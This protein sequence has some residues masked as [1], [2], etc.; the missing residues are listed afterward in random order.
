MQVKRNL[1]I[2][3]FATLAVVLIS[4]LFVGGPQDFNGRIIV[5]TWNAGHA[6]LFAI[7][8]FALLSYTRLKHDSHTKQFIFAVAFSL[9]FGFITEVIQ[10]LIGRNLEVKDLVNDLI[11]GLAGLAFALAV[12]S[13]N[14]KYTIG[15]VFVGAFLGLI[16]IRGLIVSAID[17]YRISQEFPLLSGFESLIE[18]NRWNTDHA[19]ISLSDKHTSSGS[20]SMRVELLPAKYP[21]IRLDH[22]ERNWQNK[23]SINFDIF[24]ESKSPVT[25]VLKIYD[26]QHLKTGYFFSDRY[27]QRFTLLPGQNQF[28]FALADIQSAPANREMN[29][30]NIVAVSLFTVHL[31]QPLVF[32]IDTVRLSDNPETE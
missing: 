18:L 11:G 16:G 8:T 24:S 22:F 6:V 31:K 10:Y 12:N 28:S 27:N 2:G 3:M 1:Q 26:M 4:L 25:M 5:A 32:Y 14:K 7:L 21:F 9:I 19:Q 15:G 30:S 23:K 20:Q 17:E 13:R 29:M